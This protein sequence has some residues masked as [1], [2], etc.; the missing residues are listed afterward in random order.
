MIPLT[1]SGLTTRDELGKM[2]R[3]QGDRPPRGEELGVVLRVLASN[4]VRAEEE[5][6]QDAIGQRRLPPPE[7]AVPG[8]SEGPS[9]IDLPH[10]LESLLLNRT[11]HVLTVQQHLSYANC[12]TAPIVY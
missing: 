3:R 4:Q 6:G 10:C 7:Q 5:Y 1:G 2:I 8:A 11:Y 12:S 9:Y